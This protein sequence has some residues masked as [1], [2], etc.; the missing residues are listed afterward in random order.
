MERRILQAILS[1]DT[2][3]DKGQ[4]VMNPHAQQLLG[5]LAC[6]QAKIAVVGLGYVGLPLAAEAGSIS[7]GT[8]DPTLSCHATRGHSH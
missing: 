4:S 3:I 1:L 5:A 7:S 2:L 6:H 8:G